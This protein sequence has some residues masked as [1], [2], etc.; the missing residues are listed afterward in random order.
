MKNGMED[1][2]RGF[3][4]NGLL[5]YTTAEET[6]DWLKKIAMVMAVNNHRI[7]K[8]RCTMITAQSPLPLPNNT[9]Q[10]TFI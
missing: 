7:W 3:I 10:Q 5:T 9:L 2:G 1:L 4:P 8:Y 6:D